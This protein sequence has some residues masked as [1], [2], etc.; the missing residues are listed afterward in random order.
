MKLII[1]LILSLIF[2]VP[3]IAQEKSEVTTYVSPERV[4]EIL[5]TLAE[6]IECQV[7][8]DSLKADL[9]IYN[10]FNAIFNYSS[11]EVL[12]Q[13]ENK[14]ALNE[15][16]F[17]SFILGVIRVLER[18]EEKSK[19]EVVRFLASSRV[20]SSAKLDSRKRDY[21]YASKLESHY[22]ETLTYV[23]RCRRWEKGIMGDY[24]PN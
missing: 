8:N 23:A 7:A 15:V 5:V 11:P 1:S 16:L 21:F 9:S 14:I 17:R 3:V 12:S 19:E 4:Q 13:V 2:I 20:A 10:S 18:T 24:A 22:S 6:G